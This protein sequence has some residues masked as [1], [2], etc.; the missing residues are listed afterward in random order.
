MKISQRARNTAPSPTL[1][2][3]ARARQLKAQGIDV[4]GFG[5]GEPDFDT[6]E[7]IKRAAIAALEGG[8]TKYTPS[9]GTEAL[10]KAICEKLLR[11]NGLSY[12]PNEVI[13]SAGAKHSLFNLMQAVLDPGDE[14]II[15]APYWVSYPEQVKL[16]GGVPVIVEAPESDGFRVTAA[17]IRAAVTPA[18]RMM[19]INSPS[20][21]TGAAIDQ[22][23]LRQIA[24]LAVERDLMVVSDEIYEK[25]TYGG[26]LHTSIA[27]FG[28]EIKARTF[29]VNGFSKA[30]SMTGWRLG[31]LAGDRTV[32]AA[33]GRIQDQST[34]NPTSFAQAGAVAALT[35]PQDSVE[36]MRQAFEERRNVIV[37]RLNAIPGVRCVNPD[38]AFYV[39]PNV[40]GLFSSQAGDSDALA[41][42]LLAEARIAVVPGSG[43]GAPEY[44][45]LSY[46]T[47]MEQIQ[48]GIN[49]LE[50]AARTL[51]ASGR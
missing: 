49:R 44:I 7:P 9:S 48:E 35:G 37:S 8:D 11:D 25:L 12:Q 5:A 18:T 23:E 36:T 34:S 14:V 10:R 28:E 26:S 51:R 42:Y 15:P 50:A 2:I 46:A 1:G 24:E 38:G 22:A 19:V 45:R 20:N 4:I 3:T 43:F 21:P 6:P 30:Y 33:M 29:T 39:F 27:S 16:A 17:A 31:Y 40:S 32:V 13:V 47:S 41:E